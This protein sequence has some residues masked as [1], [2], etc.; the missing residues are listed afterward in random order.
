MSAL[1]SAHPHLPTDALAG[2]LLRTTDGR[3][4][5]LDWGLVTP[6]TKDQQY[7]LVDYIANLVGALN[8]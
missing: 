1:I 2:N 8:F 7:A 3:L 4:C 6:I 5:V